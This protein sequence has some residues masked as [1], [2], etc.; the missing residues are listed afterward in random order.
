MNEALYR[1]LAKYFSGQATAEEEAAVKEWISSDPG[2]L[3]ELEAARKIWEYSDKE[4]APDFDTDA[5]WKKITAA[6]GQQPVKAKS[7]VRSIGFKLAA[8]AAVL[9]FIAGFWWLSRSGNETISVT[10]DTPVKEVL[11]EDGS[12]VYLRQNASLKYRRHFST[13]KREVA[14]TGEAF[15]D[16]AKNPEKKFIITTSQATVEVLGTSFLVTASEQEAELVV[17]TG[18]VR[19]T[20]IKDSSQTIQLRAG[21]KASIGVK[22]LMHGPNTD[23]NYNSWQTG[24]LSF[25]NTTLQDVALALSRH[26][27]ITCTIRKGEEEKIGPTL[28]TTTFVNQPLEKVRKELEMITGFQIRMINNTACEISSQ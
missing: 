8:A 24:V 1:L 23:D 11:L 26:Y 10:A 2:H 27:H 6:I 21:E 20:S 15:F 5:A 4:S 3:D 18:L 7:F 14:L 13:H 19:F 28:V 22:G 17:K 25:R 16:V 9:L 12:R